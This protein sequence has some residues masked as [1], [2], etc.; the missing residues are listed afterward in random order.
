MRLRNLRI[1]PKHDQETAIEIM[2][3]VLVRL[4]VQDEQVQTDNGAEFQAPF[5]WRLTDQGIDEVYTR[6]GTPLLSGP[7]EIS[8]RMDAEEFHQLLEAVKID[9]G[10]RS[11]TGSKDARTTAAT[12]DPARH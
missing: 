10:G 12:G 4:L 1:Y 8:R 3:C 7:V 2:H 5:H 6:P 9:G 11:T